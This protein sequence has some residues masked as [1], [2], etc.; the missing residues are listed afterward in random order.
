M[1]YLFIDNMFVKSQNSNSK[2]NWIKYNKIYFS[3]FFFFIKI[4]TINYYISKI[5]LGLLNIK[6][7]T[8]QNHTKYIKQLQN[9]KRKICNFSR[10]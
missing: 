8:K 3:L 7:Y 4:L 9:N 10:I 6:P 1:L 5:I 2:D